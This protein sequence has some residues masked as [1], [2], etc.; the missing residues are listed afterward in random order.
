MI[1]NNYTNLYGIELRRWERI[2]YKDEAIKMSI[3][4]AYSPKAYTP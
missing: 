4:G 2:E 3:K 1:Q